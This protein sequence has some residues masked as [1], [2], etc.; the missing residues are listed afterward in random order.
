LAVLVIG[1]A[2]PFGLGPGG[3]TVDVVAAQDF[4]VTRCVEITPLYYPIDA[5]DAQLLCPGIVDSVRD[6]KADELLDGTNVCDLFEALGMDDGE[7]NAKLA[8][9]ALGAAILNPSAATA[10]A[11]ASVSAPAPKPVAAAA[12]KPV[13]SATAS[14][15]SSWVDQAVRDYQVSHRQQNIPY[16]AAD[17]ARFYQCLIGRIADGREAAV[18]ACD[19]G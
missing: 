11:P 15:V 7:E 1:C 8:C 13:T 18:Q 2:I 9:R 17:L 5:S 12:P 19:G 16:T 4:A 10:S 14:G 3:S 6:A